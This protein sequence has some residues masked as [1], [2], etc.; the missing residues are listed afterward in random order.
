MTHP[1]V[2]PNPRPVRRSRGFTLLELLVALS[3]FSIAFAI[4]GVAFYTTTRAWSR[5][6]QA[7]EGLHEGDYVMDQVVSALRSA[8]W[9]RTTGANGR[10]GFWIEDGEDQYPADTISWV[11]SGSALMPPDSPYRLGLHRLTLSIEDSDLGEPSLTVRAVPPFVD[12]EDMEEPEP[13]FASG[14]V[15][16]LDCRIW[17]GELEDW[18]DEWEFTNRLPTRVE[19]ALYFDPPRPGEDPVVL[20]RLVDIPVAA[21]ATT[22]VS[23][24]ESRRR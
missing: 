8:A 7:L 21:Y 4:V 16:G 5:G 14:G 15:R 9:F 17:D 12:E 22:A 11:A 13:W 24:T 23:R 1:A 2:P 10:Y 3:I 6:T 18:I 20:R 19:I